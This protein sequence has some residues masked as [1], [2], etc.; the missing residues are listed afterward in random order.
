MTKDVCCTNYLEVFA[1][2]NTTLTQKCNKLSYTDKKITNELT[3][4]DFLNKL[5]IN[6]ANVHFNLNIN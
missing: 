1:S 5:F 6:N 2:Q 3:E 4:T